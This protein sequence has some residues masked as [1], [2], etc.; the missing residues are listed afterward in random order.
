M[1]SV[2]SVRYQHVYQH[3]WEDN[4]PR[5]R[6]S[7]RTFRRDDLA[8]YCAYLHKCFL[9]NHAVLSLGYWLEKAPR[10][11]TTAALVLLR[12]VAFYA[13]VACFMIVCH[14]SMKLFE[15]AIRT[16]ET[17]ADLADYNVR[18]EVNEN[19]D[20]AMLVFPPKTNSDHTQ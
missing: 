20:P 11:A 8:H 15:K 5:D 2:G 3:H 7:V 14:I 6:S 10:H 1:P 13:F 19:P 4:G 18:S 12:N 9:A 16:F 17:D